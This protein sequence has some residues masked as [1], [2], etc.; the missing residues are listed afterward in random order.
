MAKNEIWSKNQ[1]ISNFW[2]KFE[3]SRFFC[4]SASKWFVF[5]AEP[6]KGSSR[7]R[8]VNGVQVVKNEFPFMVSLQNWK[9]DHICGGVLL[10]EWAILTA[11]HCCAQKGPEDELLIAAAGGVHLDNMGQ[12]RVIQRHHWVTNTTFYKYTRGQ[13]AN[14]EDSLP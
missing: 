10:K 14:R 9:E 3:N 5:L 2:K 4:F 12:K 8:I 13:R 6:R 1:T 7:E 11:A